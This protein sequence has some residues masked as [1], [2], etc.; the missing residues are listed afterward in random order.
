MKMVKCFL[1]VVMAILVANCKPAKKGRID[2]GLINGIWMVQNVNLI[3]RSLENFKSIPSG[4]K[5]ANNQHLNM[6]QFDAKNNF[7]VDTGSAVVIKGTY[8][9]DDSVL[10]LNYANGGTTVEYIAMELFDTSKLRFYTNYTD[11]EYKLVYELKKN[12][13]GSLTNYDWKS[14]LNANASESE[15]KDRLNTMIQYYYYYFK[16]LGSSKSNVF[17]PA[18]IILPLKL[19]NGGV[20]LLSETEINN[21]FKTIMGSPQNIATAYKALQFAFQQPFDFPGDADNLL[22]EYSIVLKH[23]AKFIKK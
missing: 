13:M 4:E 6:F 7:T 10:T 18:K 23:L 17:K 16:Y 15:V 20:G 19:Y 22:V 3:D 2:K 9:I 8:K 5:L 12:D 14:P 1:F 11:Q 21:E